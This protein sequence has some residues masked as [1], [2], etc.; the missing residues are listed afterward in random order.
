MLVDPNTH[1]WKMIVKNR[2]IYG[3]MLPFLM[4]TNSMYNLLEHTAANEKCQKT[5]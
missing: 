1:T 5:P 2:H 4:N 3:K